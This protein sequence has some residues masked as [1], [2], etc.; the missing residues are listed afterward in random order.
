MDSNRTSGSESSAE[1]MMMMLDEETNE[2]YVGPQKG[3][4]IFWNDFES[5][6]EIDEN[7]VQETGG[8]GWGNS[9]QQ[10]SNSLIF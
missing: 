4:I 3:E 5:I 8:H 10:L 1:M 7:W 9:E 6:D 2:E